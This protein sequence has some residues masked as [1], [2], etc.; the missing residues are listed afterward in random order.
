MKSGEKDF[1]DR[2][3]SKV[4]YLLTGEV[5]DGLTG[6]VKDVHFGFEPPDFAMTGDGSR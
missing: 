6:L 2:R 1:R 4:L 3:D 5:K